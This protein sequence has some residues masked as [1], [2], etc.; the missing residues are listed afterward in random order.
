M[1]KEVICRFLNSK[2]THFKITILSRGLAAALTAE[3]SGKDWAE[4][5][6]EAAP[7]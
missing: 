4:V 2:Q 3:A 1:S 7:D 6:C 5:A